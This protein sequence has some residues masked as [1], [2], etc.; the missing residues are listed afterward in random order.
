MAAK[1]IKG[2]AVTGQ[3]KQAKAFAVKNANKGDHYQNTQT[4]N[5]YDCTEKTDKNGKSKWKY[6]KTNIV[7]KPSLAVK[8]LSSP[9][10]KTVG[11]GTRYMAASWKIPDNL[12]SDKE[13]DRAEGLHRTWWLGLPGK[14]P[15]QVKDTKNETSTSMQINLDNIKIGGKT[16]NRDSFYPNTTKKLSYVSFQVR[17]FNRIGDGSKPA[18]TTTS[19][20]APREPGIGFGFS[21][22]TG[23]VTATI[24]TNAGTDLQERYD[25]R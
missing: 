11:S 24:T 1:T 6:V 15:K 8:N 3:K 9:A 18:K 5:Y 14:D 17:P 20:K 21:K 25:T 2:T 19:F 23:V 10:R 4:G 22:E 16:Y 13:G 7:N 12:V